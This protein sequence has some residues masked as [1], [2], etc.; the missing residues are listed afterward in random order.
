MPLN[1]KKKNK[2]KIDKMINMDLKIRWIRENYP[3]SYDEAV[4][5]SKEENRNIWFDTRFW[6]NADIK[7]F[8]EDLHFVNPDAWELTHIKFSKMINNKKAEK[9]FNNWLK[10]CT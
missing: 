4:R 9:R 8:F 10:T 5:K 6:T 3:I 1:N 2:S 7:E